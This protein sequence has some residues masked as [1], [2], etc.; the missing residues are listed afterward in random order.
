[1]KKLVKRMLST[2]NDIVSLNA[3]NKT[4][5]KQSVFYSKVLSHTEKK[6]FDKTEFKN[7]PFENFVWLLWSV[8]E[9]VYKY[10]QRIMPDLLFSPIKFTVND[11]QIPVRYKVTTFDTT[12]TEGLGFNNMT[13]LKGSATY[14]SDTLYSSSIMS[15]ELILSV[16]N[17]K[18]NFENVGWGVKLIE[19]NDPDYQSAAVREFLI[20]KLNI[21]FGTDDLA[22]CK[23]PH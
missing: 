7:M 13:V 1:M 20:K 17:H 21:L 22:I 23:N 14:G 9:S 12:Q 10:L 15:D 4:R 11:V 2:G 19:K 8:K 5:T 18:E 6:L 16:V 3:V